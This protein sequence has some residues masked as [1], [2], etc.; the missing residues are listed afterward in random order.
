MLWE[1]LKD[2]KAEGLDITQIIMDHDTSGGNIACNV[3]SEIQIIYCGNHTAKIFDQELVKIKSIPCKENSCLKLYFIVF[4]VLI[5]M[6]SKSERWL[7]HKG[8]EV[9]VSNNGQP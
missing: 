3:F 6:L 4:T 1:I 2:V 8:Q 9:I 5:T 7:H